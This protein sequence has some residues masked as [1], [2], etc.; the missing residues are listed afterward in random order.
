MMV[1]GGPA[2]ADDDGLAPRVRGLDPASVKLIDEVRTGSATVR[3]LID[4]LER[5]DLI[6]YVQLAPR[7]EKP[8]AVTWILNAVPQARF[9]MISIT[10]LSGEDDRFLLLGHELRHAV[11]LADAPHVRDRA[12]MSAHYER[13]GWHD[14][15]NVYETAAA[16]EAG[17][18]VRREMLLVARGVRPEGVV[19]T[20]VAT[21]A[22]TARSRER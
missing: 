22:P 1:S 2:W 8:R 18:A 21:G 14:R 15:P 9:V 17:H 13:I 7:F 10:S 5:S 12:S 20:R 11:E 6:V 16:L 4:R 19:A 3:R